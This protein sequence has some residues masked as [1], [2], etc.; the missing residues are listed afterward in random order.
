MWA[1]FVRCSSRL[2]KNKLPLGSVVLLLV[3]AVTVLSAGLE[4]VLLLVFGSLADV[5]IVCQLFCLWALM[6]VQ[7]SLFPLILLIQ[8]ACSLS[9]L[10][11]KLVLLTV[12]TREFVP[13]AFCSASLSCLWFGQGTLSP[14]LV[15][16]DSNAFLIYNI[17]TFDK[18][19]I[20]D[21]HH[22]KQKKK[23]WK[24][25][26]RGE[27][28]RRKKHREEE[29]GPTTVQA[30]LRSATAS[31]TASKPP[32]VCPSS[33]LLLLHCTISTVLREQWRV[34]HC[35]LGQTSLAQPK[36]SGPGP[37]RSKKIQKIYIF[38]NLWF[39]RVFCY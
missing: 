37:T 12:C 9:F 20:T 29:E 17:L 26:N 22:E 23:H 5:F 8:G 19:K 18:K 28:S 11:S 25:R 10:F 15:L 31:S 32:Q 1:L 30:V 16:L 36:M 34:L 4:G 14:F 2:C 7:G 39:F 27:Q 38:E 3:S 33:F 35:S 24:N 6:L 21:L 13:F